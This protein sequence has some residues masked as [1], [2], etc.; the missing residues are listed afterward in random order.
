MPIGAALTR[1][2][3]NAHKFDPAAVRERDLQLAAA[4]SGSAPDGE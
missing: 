4:A 2:T 1:M 3:A